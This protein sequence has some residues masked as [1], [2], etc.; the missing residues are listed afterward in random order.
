MKK[1]TIF[2]AALLLIVIPAC[3]AAYLPPSSSR[4]TAIVSA[5]HLA[6]E[7]GLSILK[8]GGNAIDAAVAVGYALAV[9]HPCCGNIGGG[10]F[11]LI[12]L[13]N[14]KNIVIDFR[15][16]APAAINSKLFLNSQGR[17]VTQLAEKSY[18]S[19]GIPGTVMGLNTAL[20]K[21][22][23][24][25]LSRVMAPA[26]QLA[27]QGFILDNDDLAIL[28]SKPGDFR[29]HANVAKIFLKNNQPYHTGDRL[30]QPEL[31]RTLR[32]ISRQ[33][34]DV[35]YRGEIAKKVVA[36]S[37]ANHGVLTMKDFAEY[38]AKE[39]EVL[40]CHYRQYEIITP[41]PPSSG[42]TICEMLNILNHYKLHDMGFHSAASVHYNVEAMRYAFADHNQ[43]LGDPDFVANPVTK[44]LS[45]DYARQIV[46][47]IRPNKAGDSLL[48]EKQSATE[49]THTTH[50]GVVDQWGNAVGVTYTINAYFGAGV[51]A[52]DTGFFL[53]D[54]MD[55]FAI[56][57]GAKNMFGLRQGEANLI[58]PKKRPL[59]SMSP[60]MVFKDHQLYMVLGAAGGPTIITSILESIENV[61]DYGMN[62][63]AA[64]NE[65]RYHFQW[66]P[67]IIY[68][69]P[70]ALSHDTLSNLQSMGYSYQ[71]GSPFKTDYWGQELG[72]LKDLKTGTLYSAT[73]NRHAGGMS[74]GY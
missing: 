30:R 22:G 34:S 12:H 35:F 70:Y 26:I 27:Q 3:E 45:A 18:L 16:T 10:G 67:N 72:I 2:S 71:W 40:T 64:V 60:T 7:A 65:P 23:A 46:E 48:L 5:H 69:E 51:I 29:Q 38:Q 39:R 56:L 49:G 55:D 31:A 44:L 41:P 54:D 66:L 13:K 11:M 53:N 32:M 62:I 4:Q 63:S 57:K 43:D 24:M 15:E 21:Y 50:Y 61:I 36:A 8:A 25:P 52:G 6:S 33:G 37:Q 17:I 74:V 73:D 68:L 58:A 47:K 20:K 1:L 9:V 14:G 59:S 42:V 19:V 28:N